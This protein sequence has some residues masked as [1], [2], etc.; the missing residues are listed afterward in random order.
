MPKQQH[1][2]HTQTH[3]SANLLYGIPMNIENVNGN[4][5]C[6]CVFHDEE[7]EPAE[8][9]AN[10]KMRSQCIIHLDVCTL[11]KCI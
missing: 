9:A 2:T 7:N 11:N 5:V 4:C 6:V 10:A 3:T 1:H 8:F